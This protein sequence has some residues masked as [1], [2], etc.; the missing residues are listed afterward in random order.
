M[1]NQAVN[2]QGLSDLL[3][4]VIVDFG[5]AHMAPLVLIGD[6]LGL[7]RA[8]A[9]HG[10]LMSTQ[11]AARTETHER[12]VREW[13]NAH[14]ASGYAAYDAETGRYWLRPEQELVFADE[15]G[16]AFLAAG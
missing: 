12:Y 8:L 4:R 15:D 13:L 2:E 6:R 11:P 1:L 16:P 7:Y 14:A 5:G 9:T 10:P 3:G